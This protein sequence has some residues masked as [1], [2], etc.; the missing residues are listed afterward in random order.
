MI[1][2]WRIRTKV[3]PSHNSVE[4]GVCSRPSASE[5][6]LQTGRGEYF[7]LSSVFVVSAKIN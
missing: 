7:S 5:N 3:I 1:L 4:S 6:N 2:A